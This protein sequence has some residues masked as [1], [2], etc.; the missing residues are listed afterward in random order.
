LEGLKSG[1]PSTRDRVPKKAYVRAKGYE[2]PNFE[3]YYTRL[4]CD[5]SPRACEM[6]C[7]HEIV[8]DTPERTAE[9]LLGVA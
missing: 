9:I 1:T 8:I 4:K 5:R 2:N 7:G 3:N 6:P